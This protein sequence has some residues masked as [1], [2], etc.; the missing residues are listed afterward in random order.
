MKNNKSFTLV[1]TLAVITIIGILSGFLILRFQESNYEAELSRAKAFSL[2][3][4][5]SLPIEIVSEWKFD[6]PTT[7]GSSA[8]LDDV[9]DT[10]GANDGIAVSG[11]ILVKGGNDCVFNNC[12]DFNGTNDYIDYGNIHVPSRT[13]NRTYSFWIYPRAISTGT[14][15]STGNLYYTKCGY[16]EFR[17]TSTAIRVSYDFNASPYYNNFPVTANLDKW[18]Y[19]VLIIDVSDTTNTILKLYKNGQYIDSTTQARATGGQTIRTFLNGAQYTGVDDTKNYFFNGRIDEFRIFNDVL[20]VSQI[21]QMYLAGLDGL[22]LSNQIPKEEYSQR[23]SELK[24]NLTKH[25]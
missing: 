23:L 10:W 25:E 5:M 8:T 19:F 16:S 24:M 2:S 4:L 21:N 18:N 7:A 17:L 9:K 11:G 20:T 14:I 6:G 15:F 22:Y 3:V 13:I 1:E 12:L